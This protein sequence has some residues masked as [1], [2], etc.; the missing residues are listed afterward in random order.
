LA[1]FTKI[2]MAKRQSRTG[3]LRL[4]KIVPLVIEN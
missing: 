4:A 1:P 3:S 2:A